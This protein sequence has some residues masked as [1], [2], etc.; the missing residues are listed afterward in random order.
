MPA[1]IE[2]VHQ[3]RTGQVARID[4]SV[5]YLLYR[6]SLSLEDEI[7][8]QR[9]GLLPWRILLGNREHTLHLHGRDMRAEIVFDRMRAR[10]FWLHQPESEM[11]KPFE[12]RR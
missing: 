1:R 7:V 8:D 2:F 9:R 5:G 10:C 3:R 4:L 11:A 6:V 12:R